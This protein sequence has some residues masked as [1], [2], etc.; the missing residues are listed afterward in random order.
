MEDIHFN[1]A[2]PEKQAISVSAMQ[3]TTPPPSTNNRKIIIKVPKYQ[4]EDSS[5]TPPSPT[6]TT[7]TTPA[8]ILTRKRRKRFNQYFAA[9]QERGTSQKYLDKFTDP[10]ERRKRVLNMVHSMYPSNEMF[11]MARHPFYDPDEHGYYDEFITGRMYE[12]QWYGYEDDNEYED[13]PMHSREIWEPNIGDDGIDTQEDLDMVLAMRHTHDIFFANIDATKTAHL[14]ANRMAR[15]RDPEGHEEQE[16]E[17]EFE[18]KPESLIFVDSKKPGKQVVVWPLMFVRNARNAHHIV[19]DRVPNL[20]P[21]DRDHLERLEAEGEPGLA[22]I[23]A[24]EE[25]LWYERKWRQGIV[26]WRDEDGDIGPDYLV[27]ELERH[28]DQAKRYW[29][30]EL[31]QRGSEEQKKTGVKLIIRIKTNTTGDPTSTQPIDSENSDEAL[32]TD[33]NVAIKDI[34]PAYDMPTS[35]SSS[36]ATTRTPSKRGRLPKNGT[37]SASASTTR[38]R[39]GVARRDRGRGGRGRGRGRN[40]KASR[41]RYSPDAA[42]DPSNDADDSSDDDYKKV[43]TRAR[44]R[45]GG[46]RRGKQQKQHMGTDGA[47]DTDGDGDGDTVM[48]EYSSDA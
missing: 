27:R 26:I 45:G 1:P 10:A 19:P 14:E 3:Q 21:Q 25:A 36:M 9:K 12:G 47:W 15:E 33:S 46:T 8:G 7:S 34:S 11:H 31:R 20:S 38:G 24:Q 29:Y 5:S 4:D 32:T 35:V 17:S 48:A 41:G 6:T 30:R 2:T 13:D 44:A 39:G 22:A 42:Y 37:S 23:I 16:I 18:S 43:K 40:G 28:I